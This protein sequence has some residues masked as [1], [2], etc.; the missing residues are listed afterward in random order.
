MCLEDLIKRLYNYRTISFIYDDFSNIEYIHNLLDGYKKIIHTD[1]CF[2][3]ANHNN[4]FDVYRNFSHFTKISEL[5]LLKIIGICDCLIEVE[6]N[7]CIIR[8]DRIHSVL[9]IWYDIY[10]MV[11]EHKLKQ[12]DK[13]CN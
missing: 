8:K 11:R 13:I 7:R 3:I 4:L 9:D 6:N 10:L 1:N 2:V 5:P 12:I